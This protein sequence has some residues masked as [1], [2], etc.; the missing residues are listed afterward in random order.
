MCKA[1]ANGNYMNSILAHQEAT[2]D[3]YHEALLLDTQGYVCEGS[4]ENIF[5]VKNGKLFTPTLTSALE[6]ITR[7]SV[8]TIAKDLNIEVIE[9]NLTRDEVYTA[10]EAFFTG[11]A[12]EVTPIKQL[13][14]RNIG[15]G[16]KGEITHKI[17]SLYF[18]IV[19]GRNDKY[20]KWLTYIL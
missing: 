1:K 7:D 2:A 12:A 5:I 9:K 4:G 17:Q 3:G 19:Q 15:N 6:G 14:R 10:D 8:I 13:D 20:K 11:T 18:D 16:A